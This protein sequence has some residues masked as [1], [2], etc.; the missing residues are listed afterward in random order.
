MKSL[1]AELKHLYTA[2]TRARVNLWIYDEGEESDPFFYYCLKKDLVRLVIPDD[3]TEN[4]MFA[5]P[6]ANEQWLKQGDYYFKLRKWELAMKCY[7]KGKYLHKTYLTRGYKM[8]EEA[9]QS[10]MS[11]AEVIYKEAA[12]FFF[13]AD[14]NKHDIIFLEKGIWCLQRAKLHEAAATL[15]QKNNVS[16]GNLK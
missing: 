6:S 14:K 8:V 11:D 1:S 12:K 13:C 5:A 10:T 15:L 2:I 9:R 7:S 16:E 4:L 3:K